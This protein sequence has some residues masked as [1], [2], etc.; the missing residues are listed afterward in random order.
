MILN[1]FQNLSAG[2]KPSNLTSFINN[3]VQKGKIDLDIEA[4][5]EK[6]ILDNFIARGIVSGLKNRSF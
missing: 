6:N 5:L 4:F 1:N 3:K 2:F